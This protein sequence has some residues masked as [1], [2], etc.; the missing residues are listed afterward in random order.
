MEKDR[1]DPQSTI[2][3]LPEVDENEDALPATR[4][5]ATQDTVGDSDVLIVMNCGIEYRSLLICPTQSLVTVI[6]AILIHSKHTNMKRMLSKHGFCHVRCE[7]V[8]GYVTNIGRITQQKNGSRTLDFSLANGSEDEVSLSQADVHAD[9]S[10]AKEDTLRPSNAELR[11]MAS[12]HERDG[13]SYHVVVRNRFRLELDVC[14]NT[15][16]TVVV[17]FDEP[18]TELVKCSVDSLAAADEDVVRLR[19]SR[20]RGLLEKRWLEK[21]SD[22]ATLI[23]LLRVD[24]EDS[25]D[26][27]TCGIDDRQMLYI[28]Q[29]ERLSEPLSTTKILSEYNYQATKNMIKQNTHLAELMQEVQLIIWNEAQMR[30]KYAF[31][32]LDKTLRDILG[33]PAPERRNKILIYLT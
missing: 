15:A 1:Q 9:Y 4:D 32:A 17:I 8:V 20:A 13:T 10:Q 5:L 19:V 7:D 28:L 22:Q 24:L 14:D 31:E 18:T 21:M 16:S 6:S 29:I 12:G 26:E 23:H 2:E 33:Y 11:L 3:A 30:Q 25:D 27:V